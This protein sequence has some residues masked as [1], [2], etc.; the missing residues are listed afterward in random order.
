MIFISKALKSLHPESE[1]V[2]ENED[3]DTIRWIKNKPTGYDFKNEKEKQNKLKILT[4]EVDR[5][6]LLEQAN[7]YQIQRRYE[8]PKIQ[9]QLD[10]LWHAMDDGILPKVNQF[11]NAIAEVKAKYPKPGSE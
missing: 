8:Y 4:D 5:L 2:I 10:M 9:D 6:N 3:I 11:Y 7:A 1:F